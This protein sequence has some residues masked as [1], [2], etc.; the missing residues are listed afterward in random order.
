MKRLLM[1]FAL[2]V[3][4]ATMLA[5]LAVF[6]GSASA[7]PYPYLVYDSGGS[8]DSIQAAMTSL[9]FTFDVRNAAT[10]VTAADLASHAAL[11]I[12]WSGPPGI[13]MSGLSATVL[14]TG[15]TGNKLLTGHDPDWH[16]VNGVS[17][18]ATFMTR[19]VLFAGGSPGNCGILAFPVFTDGPFSYLPS[20]WG[21]SAFDRFGSDTI[22]A[23]TA[24]GVSSGLYGGLSLASLSDWNQSYHAGFTAFGAG[25]TAFELGMND[26]PGAGATIV[27]IG[28]TVTPINPVPIPGAVW[29]LGSGLL[30]LV[31]IGRKRLKKV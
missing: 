28:T 24:D 7:T 5:C 2:M 26:I 29:L 8:Q 4:V 12:G 15:I 11:I 3:A 18:A 1:V 31:G 9:G 17:A 19:A 10:P 22:T 21:I 30:G 25:L 27:T 14:G 16:T 13:D 23:I 6:G 20:A